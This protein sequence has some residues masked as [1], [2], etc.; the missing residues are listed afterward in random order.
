VIAWINFAV[1]IVAGALMAYLYVLSVRPVA[2]EQKVGPVAYKRCARCRFVSSLFMFVVMAN[3]VLYRFYP[4]PIDPFPHTFP[5]PYWVSAVVAAVI[6]IPSLY[7]MG[8]AMLDAGEETML[9]KKEHVMYSGIYEKIRHPMAVGEVPSWWVI[10]FLLNSPFLVLLSVVWVPV[11]L[12]WCLAE[13]KDLLLRYGEAYEAYRRRTG[14]F[15][16]RRQPKG[17]APEAG[18]EA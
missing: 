4:L 11:W 3:Y 17:Q 7:L 10:A 2:L 6:G 12:W 5:W 18:K 16:P 13:E 9:P 14:A 1:L 8:R 15:F